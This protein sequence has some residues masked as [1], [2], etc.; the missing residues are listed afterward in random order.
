M[1]SHTYAVHRNYCPED[2]VILSRV[3]GGSETLVTASCPQRAAPIRQLILP[4]PG[5]PYI[6]SL[7]IALAAHVLQTPG[8][9]FIYVCTRRGDGQLHR[10]SDA[11]EDATWLTPHS[12]RRK[13]K[14]SKA[15]PSR[16]QAATEQEK[17]IQEVAHFSHNSFLALSDKFKFPS[18]LDT[19]ATSP[20]KTSGD[21]HVPLITPRLADDL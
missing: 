14:S 18:D 9:T 11:L 7:H 15:G 2:P 12:K 19:G 21:E 4:F 3:S 1:A 10:A 20:S 5:V 6:G 17:A 13:R 16:A 8:E